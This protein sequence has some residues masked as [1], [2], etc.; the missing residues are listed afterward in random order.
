MRV[1]DMLEFIHWV[2]AEVCNPD[3]EWELIR[4]YFP[5]VACRKLLNLGIVKFV[6]GEY[7]YKPWE[8]KS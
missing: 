4:E 7:V 8:D 3:E 1:E 2:A 5:E 6:S